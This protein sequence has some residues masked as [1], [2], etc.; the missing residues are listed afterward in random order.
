MKSLKRYR[1][2]FLSIVFLAL[3]TLVTLRWSEAYQRSLIGYQSP[4]V[5]LD[6]PPG[7]QLPSQTHRLILVVVSGLSYDES[8]TLE[9]PILQTLRKAGAS[10]PVAS[11]APAFWPGSWASTLTGAW[12]VLTGMPILDSQFDRIDSLKLDNTFAAARDAGQKTVVVGSDRWRQVLPA[13]SVT[14]SFYTPQ[15]G[16]VADG[17]VVKAALGYIGDPQYSLVLIHLSQMDL[18]GRNDGKNSRAYAGAAQQTDSYLRQITRQINLSNSVLVITSDVALTEDGQST[19]GEPAPPD[20]PLIVTGQAI[21][22]GVY[23]PVRQIDLAP[24]FSLLLGT[25]LPVTALGSPLFDLVEVNTEDAV[26]THLLDAA[27]KVMLKDSYRLAMGREE[28]DSLSTQD[29][30][31][32]RDAWLEG[33]SAGA[34]QLAELVVDEARQEMQAATA[35]RLGAARRGRLPI[36]VV[37]VLVPLF[38]AWVRRAGHSWLIAAAAFVTVLVFYGLY[39]V[40]GYTFT[41]S[42]TIGQADISP[43]TSFRD[44]AVALLAGGTVM[45][46][47]LLS[48]RNRQLLQNVLLVYDFNTALVC[49][50]LLPALLAFWQY[51][52]AITWQLP[53]AGVVLVHSLALRQALVSALG[54]LLL[55]WP[56]AALVTFVNRRRSRVSPESQEWDP[57]AYLRR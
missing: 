56:L 43:A 47:G 7:E 5:D 14:A 31:A 54:G 51:G 40:Q 18:V 41:F 44:A 37:L 33:N 21:V 55:P 30:F 27:Q 50:A 16:A 3:A 8:V 12:P 39:R 45:L 25:R 11:Q 1:S 46:F 34:T 15:A 23:S 9:M 6:I 57:I 38:V 48:L 35:G 10:A 20:L 53:P 22:A 2:I 42:D 36:V 28:T 32:A 49:L 4:L 52:L 29:L 26:L 19:G 13:D 24:T 17:E